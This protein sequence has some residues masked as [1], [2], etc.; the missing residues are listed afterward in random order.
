M[1]SRLAEDRRTDSEVSHLM[2]LLRY[3]SILANKYPKPLS[4]KDLADYAHVSKAA[5][6]KVRNRLYEICDDKTLGRRRRL[7]LRTDDRTA[8]Q[9][10]V[11]FFL[12]ARLKPLLKSAYGKS[13]VRKWVHEYYRKIVKTA[14]E[15]PKFLG[16]DDAVF[17]SELITTALAESVGHLDFTL[18]DALDES[19]GQYAMI[20]SGVAIMK[21]LG[22]NLQRSIKDE[23]AVHRILVIRDKA[24]FFLL[25]V[26]DSR[27][28]LVFRDLL[29]QIP[30][31]DTRRTYLS[32]YQRTVEFYLRRAVSEYVTKPIREAAEKNR[33]RF[34]PD[35]FELGHFF[36]PH[37]T[38]SPAGLSEER[39]LPVVAGKARLEEEPGIGHSSN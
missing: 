16:E 34:D 14:P 23:A 10:F 21:R 1:Q 15:L 31:D 11:T 39:P 8:G 18:L 19:G 6:S 30:E 26:I 20:A 22:P 24:W 37:T 3:V 33:V 17:V 28:G 29:E 7:L 2:P 25:R 38:T 9:V 12:G 32:V 27:L 13:L 35:Y 5:V 4:H 36:Q